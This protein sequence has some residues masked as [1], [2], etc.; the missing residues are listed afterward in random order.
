ML[1]LN[2]LLHSFGYFT[3]REGRLG[4]VKRREGQAKRHEGRLGQG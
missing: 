2:E 3:C 4:L 1:K